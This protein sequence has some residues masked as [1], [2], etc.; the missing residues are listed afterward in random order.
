MKLRTSDW[1]KLRRPEIEEAAK[2]G[3]L[4]V[5]PLG[6]TEQHGLHLPM[7]V[8][9]NCAQTL[10]VRA[11]ERFTERPV[12][13]APPL[14]IG[15]SP[16][17]MPFA[18]TISLSM[19]LVMTLVTEVCRCVAAH[20]FRRILVV[21]GHLG[22]AVPLQDVSRQL[23]SESIFMKPVTYWLLVPQALHDFFD[24]DKGNIG[25]AGEIETS[26]QLHFQPEHADMTQAVT[27]PGVGGNPATATAEKG[28]RL[29][30]VTVEALVKEL[31]E[32][33]R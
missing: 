3:A 24:V 14:T 9:I 7:D 1:S 25:H 26:L 27:V 20:G 28:R 13:V 22:H 30:E 29:A 8:D 10:A 21:N 2:A 16:S 4:V 17:F 5:L 18:G 32:L 19:E 15:C 6:T 11:A 33:A 12:L 23:S 31:H